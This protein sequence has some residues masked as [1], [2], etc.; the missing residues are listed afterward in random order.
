LC[1]RRIVVP[2]VFALALIA[3]VEPH[4]PAG[5]QADQVVHVGVSQ[6]EQHAD[7][8]YA[9]D[10][11]Y[12]KQAGLD[13]DVQ[14]LNS[15]GAIAAAVAGGSL[16]IAAANPLPVFAAHERGLDFAIVV[17]GA[18]Y[19]SKTYP[20]NFV[21]A[22][23]ST[24]RTGK[25]F[26]GST[27]AVTSLS[28]LD[29]LGALA[30]IDKTGGDWHKVKFIELT[31]AAEADAV[32]DGRVAAALIADPS[33]PIAEG[34]VR[35][36]THSYDAIGNHFFAALWFARRDWA[37]KNPDV[38]RRFRIAIDRAGDWATRN[39]VPAAPLLK[40]D[41]NIVVD[42]A[43]EVHARSV[44]ESMLQPVIDAAV[45]YGILDHTMDARDVIW[46]APH[47]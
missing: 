5:A 16:Q 30:W 46:S 44:D 33:V 22:P 19:D 27:I 23:Q 17:P 14:I 20:A 25:D 8:L 40:K 13:V 29:P 47:G 38:V 9:R 3:A 31:H 21:I 15:G 35:A 24:R 43:H 37:D 4:R 7:A 10:L 36:L 41:M 6:F 18:L 26:E 39:P 42:R 34:K 11:G 1:N 2:L 32:A 12:F 28:G 45:K